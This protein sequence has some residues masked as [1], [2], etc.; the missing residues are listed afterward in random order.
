ML[1]LD[2]PQAGLKWFNTQVLIHFQR[3]WEEEQVRERVCVCVRK[4]VDIATSSRKT[5]RGREF[6]K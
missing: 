4:V 2:F 3:K 6:R 5:R 1:C